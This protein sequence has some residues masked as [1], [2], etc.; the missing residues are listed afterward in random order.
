MITIIMNEQMNIE[1]DAATT[2]TPVLIV[3][4]GYAGTAAAFFLAQNGVRAIA[5][6]RHDGPSVQGRARGVNQRTMEL[7]RTLGIHN[8]VEA[9]S[10]PFAGDAGV[11]RCA[12]LT[13]AWDWLFD[14]EPDSRLA[15]V[16]PSTF[17]MADQNTVEPGAD[18][19]S[20][21]TRCHHRARHRRRA[22]RGR[23]ERC[24]GNPTK[25]G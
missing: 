8:E 16:S 19:P 7:Y 15:T 13:G 4:G 1:V 17:V 23:R 2:H 3:G 9:L 20:T 10:A 24:D 21:R 5:V 18:P 11:A 22:H 6:D 14:P 12:T 25:A